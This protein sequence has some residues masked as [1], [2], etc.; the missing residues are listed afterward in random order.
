MLVPKTQPIKTKQSLTQ[1]FKYG[2]YSANK[3]QANDINIPLHLQEQYEDEYEYDQ[4]NRLNN[5]ENKQTNK[6]FN[7]NQ[8]PGLN[9]GK[10]QNNI[11]TPQNSG[12][13]YTLLPNFISSKNGTFQEKNDNKELQKDKN[14][15]LNK[16]QHL[17]E[18]ILRNK[19]RRQSL[20][21]DFLQKR[22]IRN[23]IRKQSQQYQGIMGVNGGNQYP[24]F[25]NSSQNYRGIEK[26][27]SKDYVG[28]LPRRG[29]IRGIEDQL[30]MH[31][32]Q[33]N[34]NLIKNNIQMQPNN[35]NQQM[36][37]NKEQFKRKG[38][39]RSMTSHGYIP[40]RIMQRNYFLII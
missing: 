13:T 34:N 8:Y 22:E 19:Q 32:F 37:I 18:Q 35:F 28:D 5:Q 26:Q 38:Q 31:K 20:N 10:N 39:N 33:Q 29:S 23:Q 12:R 16:N 17:K 36:G 30:T 4:D 24:D 6:S 9:W 7:Y 27:Q 15:Y 21:S 3:L 40:S 11:R 2:L 14:E 25:L 1:K